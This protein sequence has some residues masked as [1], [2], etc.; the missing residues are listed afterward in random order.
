MYERNRIRAHWWARQLTRTEDSTEQTF[1]LSSLAAVGEDACGAVVRLADD[2]RA[3]IRSLAVIALG[4]LPDGGGIDALGRLLGDADQDVAE[5]AALRLAFAEGAPA[6]E[7]A[8]RLLMEG[9]ASSESGVAAA[10]AAALSQVR[11]PAALAALGR[12]VREHPAPR[13]RAQAVES[14]SAVLLAARGSPEPGLSAAVESDSVGV[15][16]GALADRATF[17]GCLSLERQI[18]GAQAFAGDRGAMPTTAF[19]APTISAGR[20]VAEVAAE[21]IRR[22]IGRPI[23]P[24]TPRTADQSAALAA[25]CRRAIA[26]G[27]GGESYGP[28]EGMADDAEAVGEPG[29][30]QP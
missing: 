21:N 1:Y 17:I 22:L 14:L 24:A 16:V 4:A 9:V 10:A 8:R 19:V 15:L 30:E 11:S 29:G 26:E 25:E 13:V 28:Q 18:A 27:G 12:A 20:T 6:E 7:R 2:K 5:S 3:E 23:D